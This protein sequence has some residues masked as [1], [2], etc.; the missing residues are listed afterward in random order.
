M[1]TGLRSWLDERPVAGQ[2]DDAS[3]WPFRGHKAISTGLPPKS[4]REFVGI[5]SDNQRFCKLE[6]F[7]VLAASVAD[8]HG[9]GPV[10]DIAQIR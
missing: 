7:P 10:Q 9:I 6:H 1:I 2:N 5:W 8:C 4:N 3:G